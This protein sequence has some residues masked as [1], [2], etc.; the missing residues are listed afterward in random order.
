MALSS[1]AASGV[2]NIEQVKQTSAEYKERELPSPMSDPKR[3][4]PMSFKRDS[5]QRPSGNEP[6]TQEGH[7]APRLLPFRNRDKEIASVESLVESLLRGESPRKRTVV[8]E[9]MRN[10]GKTRLLLHLYDEILRSDDYLGEVFSLFIAFEPSETLVRAAIDRGDILIIEESEQQKPEQALHTIL[11]RITGRLEGIGVDIEDAGL[12]ERVNWLVRSVEKWAQGQ[13][14]ALVLLLDAI[15]GV[16]ERFAE[17][18]EESLLVPLLNLPNTLLVMSGRPPFPVWKS[19]DLRIYVHR[20]RLGLLPPRDGKDIIR[21]M[22][23]RYPA[24]QEFIQ[25]RTKEILQIADGNPGIMISLVEKLAELLVESKAGPRDFDVMMAEVLNQVIDDQLESYVGFSEKRTEIRQSVE[26]LSVLEE[27]FREPE[28]AWL[29]GDEPDVPSDEDE[30]KARRIRELLH[31]RKLIEWKDGAFYLDDSI[32]H[33]VVHYLKHYQ[34]AEWE[35]WHKRAKRM[36][37][38]YAE[39]YPQYREDFEKLAKRHNEQLSKSSADPVPE[40]RS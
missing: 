31:R 6:T 11:R 9:G 22:T 26:R 17:T 15:S 10:M 19:P 28:M 8:F 5:G 40:P 13:N 39:E 18:L 35:R 1:M 3:G 37:E 32:R 38:T 2:T 34:T 24:T 12:E 30:G 16:D 4:H 20:H 25:K 23:A 36:Y 14:R 27:G 7:Q 21:E 33:L 29:L